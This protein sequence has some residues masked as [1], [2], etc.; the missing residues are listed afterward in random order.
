MVDQPVYFSVVRMNRRI[1]LNG[2]DYNCSLGQSGPEAGV[3][4]CGRNERLQ[5]TL[6]R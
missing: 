3:R 5:S 4:T 1:I 6:L 2:Q